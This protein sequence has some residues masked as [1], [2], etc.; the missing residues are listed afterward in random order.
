MSDGRYPCVVT[1]IASVN[2]RES[3]GGVLVETIPSG[4]YL[5]IEGLA[6]YIGTDKRFAGIWYKF[7]D[8]WIHSDFVAQVI[9]KECSGLDRI[10][11]N[12]VQ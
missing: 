6:E 4:Y 12:A 9:G 2:I 1:T 7:Y 3:P 10:T 11:V 5:A 8:A